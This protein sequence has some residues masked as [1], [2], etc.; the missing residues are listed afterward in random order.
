M[1]ETLE[2]IQLCLDTAGE[3]LAFLEGSIKAIPG[4]SVYSIQSYS[5]PFD[6]EKQV[7]SFM[8]SI[9]YFQ[10]LIIEVGSEFTLTLGTRVHTFTVSSWNETEPNWIKLRVDL[11]SSVG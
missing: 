11:I 7:Y 4:V 8:T 9:T 5:S 1:T 3:E 6:V 2:M 10:T